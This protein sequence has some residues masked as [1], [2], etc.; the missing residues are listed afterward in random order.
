MTEYFPRF[1][2]TFC[3]KLV[4]FRNVK[5]Y[6][7]LAVEGK[8]PAKAPGKFYRKGLSLIEMIR[9]FPDDEAAERWFY[10]QR[11]PDGLCCPRCGDTNVQQKTTHPTMPH[12][13]RG[14]R[15][16]FSVRTGTPMEASNLGL[17]VW[18]LAIYLLCTHLKGQSSMKLHRDLSVTQ[19]TA[20]HLAHRIREAWNEGN[21]PP[22]EDRFDGPVEVDETF[23]GGLEKN[24]HRSKRLRVGGGTA[25]K[26]V[27]A[28]MK[29]RATNQ[30][31]AAVV[32]NRE[33]WVLQTFIRNRAKAGATVYTD[34]FSGYK[35]LP[36][37]AHEPVN[38]SVGEYVRG[39]AHTQ[40]IESMWSML[41]RGHK[42]TYH[43]MSWRHL[44]RYVNK[45]TGRHNQREL[46]TLDQMTQVVLG[47]NGKRL[48][49]TDLTGRRA[50]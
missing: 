17:Q 7:C 44:N 49:Y 35:N 6:N 38:H 15:K 2:I 1:S 22:W 40:G 26:V 25:G 32:P 27:V 19:K 13:C 45:F 41:K 12:R 47:M 23:M 43:R 4:D 29:D 3:K 8:D 16:F 18:A 28:G 33:R 42:G 11:W 9:M 50:A 14:C 30:V 37:Y 10:A 5:R 31:K 48:R 20:W 34:D 46:D 21:P 24:K 36:D 39:K